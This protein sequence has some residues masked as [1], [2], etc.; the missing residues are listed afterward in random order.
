MAIFRS[1]SVSVLVLVFA[2]SGVTAGEAVT[3][4]GG[5]TEGRLAGAGDASTLKNKLESLHKQSTSQGFIGPL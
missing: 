2:A 3:V 1:I 4:D 5:V